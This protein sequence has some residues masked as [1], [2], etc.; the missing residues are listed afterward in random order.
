MIRILPGNPSSPPSLTDGALVVFPGLSVA[1]M[2]GL[3]PHAACGTALRILSLMILALP[4]CGYTLGYRTPPGVETVGVPI[5]QNTT[6]PLRREV[7]FDLTSRVRKGLERRSPLR[8][9]HSGE[10]DLVLRGTILE[11]RE[12]L[13]I[14][15]ERDS[16]V[17]SN[18][19][20]VVDVALEDYVNGTRLVR[21]ITT[22]EPFSV[23]AGESFETGRGRAIDNLAERI[24]SFVEYW[25]EYD[26]Y[27]GERGDG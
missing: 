18:L 9:V 6:F 13:V 24:V 1:S 25:D 14:E 4:G 11:F 3:Y 27:D 16:R 26:E 2:G 15:G 20:A 23:A 8:V 17:E 19:V 21:R 5:F 22:T 7:E 12:S 10:A